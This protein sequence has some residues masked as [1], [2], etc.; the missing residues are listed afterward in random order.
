MQAAKIISNSKEK[1]VYFYNARVEFLGVPVAY[2]PYFSTPDP[3]VKR[4]SGL[5]DPVFGY[6]PQTGY[7]IG[8][9]LFLGDLAPSYDMTLDAATI[10]PSRA[11]L[12]RRNGASGWRTAVHVADGRHRPAGSRGVPLTVRPAGTYAQRDFR[13]GLRT[14]GSFDINQC[15]SFGWDGTLLTDRTFTRNYDVLSKETYEITRTST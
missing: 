7:S 4:K 2:V 5:P 10:S 1:M 15:W 6:S 14:T 12:A 11:S 13:G 3:S 9:P 8:H